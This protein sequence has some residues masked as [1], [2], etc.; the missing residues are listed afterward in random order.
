MG[1]SDLTIPPPG[2][3]SPGKPPD[4]LAVLRLFAVASRVVCAKPEN[5]DEISKRLGTVLSDL[6][7]PESLAAEDCVHLWRVFS[8]FASHPKPMLREEAGKALCRDLDAMGQRLQL[9]PLPA[10]ERLPDALIEAAA[11]EETTEPNA[12]KGVEE[13]RAEAQKIY[14]GLG[15]GETLV[16][17][18]VIRLLRSMEMGEREAVCQSLVGTGHLSRSEVALLTRWV[19][20]NSS[21][22][23]DDELII[24]L[25]ERVGA[26]LVK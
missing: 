9:P 16:V 4:S 6:V 11:R 12:G 1:N 17:E 25:L 18:E 20:A 2:A 14:A 19:A 24:E 7:P 10:W 22:E 23:S 8:R 3:F 15:P 26:W 13:I 5:F 21:L